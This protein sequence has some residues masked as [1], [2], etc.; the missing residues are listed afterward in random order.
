MRTYITYFILIILIFSK[1]V[2]IVNGQATSKLYTKQELIE[3]LDFVVKTMEEAHPNLY[4]YETKE[5]FYN[6]FNYLKASI[7]K[8]LTRHEFSLMAVPLF[9]SLKAGHTHLELVT[10]EM[11]QNL[12]PTDLLFPFVVSLK[13][14]KIRIIKN[15]SDNPNLIIEM[16]ILEINHKPASFYL[17]SLSVYSDTKIDEHKFNHLEK[18]FSILLY[19]LFGLKDEFEL[20]IEQPNQN[21][22]KKVIVCGITHSEYKK[23][24]KDS[25]N[26]YKEQW[27][28]Y[29]LIT[30]PDKNYAILDIRGF[31][32]ESINSFI[33][34]SFNYLNTSKIPNLIIDF[35]RHGG[36]N[37]DL[38]YNLLSYISDKP[39]SQM[40]RVDVKVSAQI[41]NKLRQ[42]Q[43]TTNFNVRNILESPIGTIAEWVEKPIQPKESAYK[44]KVFLLTGPWTCSAG[45]NFS[46][47]VKDYNLATIIG[48]P[49]GGL[50][51][52]YGDRYSFYAPNTGLKAGVACCYFLRPAGYDDHKP[53]L[54]D[55]EIQTTDEDIKN[56]VDP[57]MNFT[58]NLIK[59]DKE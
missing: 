46:V 27:Y 53:V 55:Y 21:K 22:T 26:T 51:S 2:L 7:N 13:N 18:D 9:A 45:V 4:H 41:K 37:S 50:A 34:S 12:N 49:T 38:G 57:V 39:V 17:D 6:K 11:Y 31:Y 23:R 16:E 8:P 36:G 56:N 59:N 35:R 32:S 20:L 44:G 24:K 28:E 5:Q 58:L 29:K 14:N 1:S 10:K 54:P 30:Y 42:G 43:D 33:D 52:T 25:N 48:E 19:K 15:L 40:K 3:D 47:T